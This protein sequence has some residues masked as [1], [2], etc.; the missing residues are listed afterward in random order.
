MTT[1]ITLK[2]GGVPEHFN[3]PWLLAISNG[4]FSKQGINLQWED[5]PGGTGAMCKDLREGTLDVAI[6][7]TE[8]IVADIINGNPGK[9]MQTYVQ[10][11][12][13][14]GV[15]VAANSTYQSTADAKGK[16]F[17]ISRYF[18]GSH[19]MAY[20]HAHR[21]NWEAM[22]EDFIVVGN[23]DGARNALK[24]EEA[25]L[26]L[27]EKYTTKPLVDVGEF[28]RIDECPT[29]WPSFVIAVR[30]EVLKAHPEAIQNMLEVINRE[31]EEFMQNPDAA[32]II[33]ENY[34]LELQDAQAWLKDVRWNTVAEM[35]TNLLI[36][37]S[38]VLKNLGVIPAKLNKEQADEMTGLAMV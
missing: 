33:A 25:E 23:L 11:P 12:L 35:D 15:H 16:R 13:I 8:G 2:A 22:E 32:K 28:R 30:E 1:A 5:Y 21:N 27:W 31:T 18:S 3:Y 17:A 38:S 14:W 37:V 20:V 26:F 9:I 7:L 6:L 29:P 4:N 34:H 10:S 24:K 19:L 36:E